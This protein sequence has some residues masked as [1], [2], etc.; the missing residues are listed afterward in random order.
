MQ[1]ILHISNCSFSEIKYKAGASRAAPITLLL[2][3]RKNLSCVL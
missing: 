2:V 1:S 3:W